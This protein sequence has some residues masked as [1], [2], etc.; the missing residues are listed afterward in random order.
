MNYPYNPRTA[1]NFPYRASKLMVCFLSACL[2]SGYWNKSDS[3]LFRVAIARITAMNVSASIS[4]FS[5]LVLSYTSSFRSQSSESLHLI[6]NQAFRSCRLIHLFS[7]NR[8]DRLAI[9]SSH[10]PFQSQSPELQHLISIQA[11]RSC[12]RIQAH[13][14]WSTYSD[15][16]KLSS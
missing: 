13:S 15:C 16:S 10:S 8:Q 14:V 12:P 4:D 7:H 11:F 2:T 3:F 6:R 1:M 5:M 9:S